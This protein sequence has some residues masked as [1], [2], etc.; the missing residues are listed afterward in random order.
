[1]FTSEV[2]DEDFDEDFSVGEFFI[3]VKVLI[4]SMIYEGS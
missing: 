2:E 3:A 4:S 1:L